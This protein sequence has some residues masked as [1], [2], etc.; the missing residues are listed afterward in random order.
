MLGTLSDLLALK[1]F[2]HDTAC[3]R[4]TSLLNPSNRKSQIAIEYYHRYRN[5][6]QD[7]HILWVHGGSRARFEESYQQIATE[8][9]L[10][11]LDDP[12]RQTLKM[13]RDWLNEATNT[14]WLLILDNLNDVDM[15]FCS[16]PPPSG[17][18][19][20]NAS[21]ALVDHLPRTFIGPMLITTRDRRLGERP[22]PGK[23]P[24]SVE[25]FEMEDAEC[26]L[27]KK[28]EVNGND[29]EAL[30]C[31]LL[32]ALDFLPLAI[33]QATAFLRRTTSPWQIT[34]KSFRTKMLK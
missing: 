12:N 2:E 11:G 6:H 5:K 34:L 23:R 28:V 14:P 31:E 10:P 3:T 9:P 21:E 25:P 17:E 32:R 24:I 7:T 22:A 19:Q 33:T 8:L 18:G 1:L 29:D 4:Y 15:V 20:G 26:L 16:R 27:S 30:S 13:V